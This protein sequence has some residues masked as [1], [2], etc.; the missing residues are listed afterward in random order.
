MP[1][2]TTCMSSFA[3]GAIPCYTFS[4]PLRCQHQWSF[5]HKAPCT[6]KR[7]TSPGHL[8][9]SAGRSVKKPAG[10]EIRRSRSPVVTG[11]WQIRVKGWKVWPFEVWPSINVLCIVYSFYMF[12]HDIYNV[13]T[14]YSTPYTCILDNQPSFWQVYLRPGSVSQ[15]STD[16]GQAFKK[17]LICRYRSRSTRGST[18]AEL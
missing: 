1:N 16:P 18:R 4:Q 5:T 9:R 13:W 8:W 7:Y 3:Y 6:I 2:S 14:L 15:R 11:Q 12:I 10:Q 17:L